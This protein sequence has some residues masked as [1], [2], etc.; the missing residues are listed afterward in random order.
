MDF[1]KQFLDERTYLKGV[2]PATIRYY[3]GVRHTFESILAEPTKAG[4]L[5]RV[6]KLLA[7]GV[8]P[9]SVNTYLRGFKA[10]VRWLHAEGYLKELFPIRF[11]KTEQK[12]LATLTPDQVQRIMRYTPDGVNDRRIHTFVLLVLDTGIRLSEAL[13]L[14]RDALDFDN[15]VIKVRGKGG[16]HRLVPFSTDCRKLVFRYLSR[17][18][19]ADLVFSTRT[20][21]GLTDRNTAR[22]MRELGRR[23]RITGVRFSPHTLRHTFAVT[24]LRNG[25]DVYMLSRILGHSNI[26]TTTVY[27]R[28]IG[29][30][31]LAQAHQKFSPLVAMS[32]SRA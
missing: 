28:S 17:H 15:L 21:T 4:M 24:F 22:D 27:L 23:L 32:R 25:G 13:N 3:A 11:L 10:Y 12:V 14:T 5:E 19:G 2:S 6:Q 1:F 29:I 9:I 30:E 20:G 16:K 26:T 8:S 18:D 7:D 31:A